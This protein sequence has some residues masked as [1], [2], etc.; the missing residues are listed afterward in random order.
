MPEYV[1]KERKEQVSRLCIQREKKR[2][3]FG[4]SCPEWQYAHNLGHRVETGGSEF[5]TAFF[6]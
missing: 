2:K 5:W 4:Q 6:E 1:D 3:V